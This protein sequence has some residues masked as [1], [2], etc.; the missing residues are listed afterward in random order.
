MEDLKALALEYF[1][2]F[3]KKDLSGVTSMFTGEVSLKDWEIDATGIVEVT[4]ATKKIFDSVESITVTPL[5]IYSEG[6]TVVA[7][8][9]INVQGETQGKKFD[10][11]LA[12]LDVLT[13]QG[14]KI[15]SIR[16]YKG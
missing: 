9:S 13:F 2:T 12:V 15:S 1:Q 6:S 5:K 11:D 10:E 7:E 3:S 16:A 14:R 8:L 4:E